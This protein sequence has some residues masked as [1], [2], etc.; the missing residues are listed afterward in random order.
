MKKKALS[1]A[2]VVIVREDDRTLLLLRPKIARWAPLKWGFPG[3]KI[4]EGETPEAAAVRETKEETDLDVVKLNSLALKVDKPIATYY[5]RDYTG[6]V[7]IDYE[8]DDWAWV[9][10][11]EMK[12]YELAPQVK[13]MFEWVLNHD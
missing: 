5:T 2:V 11:D 13:E 9:S 8:H 7:Q 10:L 4:E 1:G 12:D 3:G 6:N